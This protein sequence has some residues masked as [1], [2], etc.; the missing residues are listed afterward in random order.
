MKIEKILEDNS[1]DLN[2]YYK[3]REDKVK[4][5]KE[6][7]N[8]YYD[9]IIKHNNRPNIL[10]NTNIVGQKIENLTSINFD[11]T[12]KIIIFNESKYKKRFAELQ[13]QGS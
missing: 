8:D 3:E 13:K 6:L 7:Q 5:C 12:E 2:T 9:T 10:L 1:D 4:L 11:C